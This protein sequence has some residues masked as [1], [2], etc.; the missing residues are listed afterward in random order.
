MVGEVHACGADKYDNA[1]F[2]VECGFDVVS[3]SCSPVVG[4]ICYI[5]CVDC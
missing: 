1:V 2:W 3:D 4:G 5:V